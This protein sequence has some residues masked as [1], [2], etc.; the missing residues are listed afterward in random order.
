MGARYAAR[1]GRALLVGAACTAAAGVTACGSDGGPAGGSRGGSTGGSTLSGTVVVSAAAS[2][3]GTFDRI[4]DDFG[5]AN[6]GVKVSIGYGGSDT[7]AGQINAGAPVDVFAAASDKTMALVVHAGNAAGEPAPFAA[8]TLQIAVPTDNPAGVDSLADLAQ[9]GVSVALCAPTVPC[10]AAS[11]AA[12]DAAGLD[13][14]PVTQ[15][16]DVK[17]V[18]TKVRLAEV[19]AGLVYRTDVIAAAG[20]VVGIDFPEAAQSATRYPIV[21]CDQAPNP[22]AARAFVDYVLSPAGQQVLAAAGFAA[23]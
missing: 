7:L 20:D 5:D 23:P 14:R 11:D 17:G 3:T 6:P 12:L 21:V 4:A 19:D 2:L 16:Q 13:V 15:E 1:M 9:R 18:L 10:G 8:N 22:D